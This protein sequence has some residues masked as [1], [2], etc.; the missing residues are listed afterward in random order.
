MKHGEQQGSA[1]ASRLEALL[2]REAEEL[3]VS[4]NRPIALEGRRAWL[5][6]DG[7]VEVFAVG[8]GPGVSGA[9]THIVTAGAGRML[10][11]IGRERTSPVQENRSREGGMALIAVAHPGTRLLE[12]RTELLTRHAREPANV[13]L[14]ETVIESWSAGSS[15][16]CRGARLQRTSC[17]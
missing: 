10:F 12:T 1:A 17:R 5:V 11:G 8:K 2:G 7:Q 4:G 6:A 3:A 16:G 14:L 15:I 9:R 13:A